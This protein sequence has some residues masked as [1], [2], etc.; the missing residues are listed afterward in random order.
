MTALVVI[1]ACSGTSMSE[2]K[3]RAFAADYAKAWSSQNAAS[4]AA[5]FAPEGSISINDGPP[6]VGREAI[7]AVAQRFMT[8][9]PDMVVSMDSVRVDSTGTVFHW[10]LTGT[11]T[12]PGGTGRAV[13]FSGYEE[14]MLSNGPLIVRSLGHYDQADFQ[15]QMSSLVPAPPTSERLRP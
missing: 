9:F 6:S 7:T 1:A 11:N 5:H 2:D 12:G 3:V 13:K 4:V 10:T 14:W 15:R 8:S